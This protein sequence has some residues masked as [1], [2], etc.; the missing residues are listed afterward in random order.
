MSAVV[1]EEVFL[2]AQYRGMGIKYLVNFLTVFFKYKS[3]FLAV[4][5]FL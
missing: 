4:Y 3:I 2:F 5:I 1:D